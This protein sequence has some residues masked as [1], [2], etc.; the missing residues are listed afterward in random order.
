[1]RRLPSSL[2]GAEHANFRRVLLTC[3]RLMP[4]AA[5]QSLCLRSTGVAF[6]LEERAQN[7]CERRL[8]GTFA[9]VSSA[10]WATGTGLSVGPAA[11]FQ[12]K[13]ANT[14][15]KGAAW[16]GSIMLRP[17]TYLRSSILTQMADH[18]YACALFGAHLEHVRT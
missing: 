18:K 8:R 12:F 9:R 4:S 5:P 2:M 1:M 7:R 3:W 16:V 17:L 11:R 15:L 10:L 6:G 14:G 13:L